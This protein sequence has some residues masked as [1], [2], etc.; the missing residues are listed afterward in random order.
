[1]N[2]V[3]TCHVC[4]ES[5]PHRGVSHGTRPSHAHL[6]RTREIARMLSYMDPYPQY[7]LHTC[8]PNTPPFIP[9]HSILARIIYP[10]RSARRGRSVRSQEPHAWV[11]SVVPFAGLGPTIRPRSR[12]VRSPRRAVQVVAKR[13]GSS[14]AVRVC[15]WDRP[16]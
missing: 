2:S 7:H 11:S 4:D 16:P 10:L 8:L 3:G 5:R 1:V 12:A 6:A 9:V 15:R 13:S 14:H